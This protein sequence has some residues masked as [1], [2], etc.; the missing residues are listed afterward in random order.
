MAPDFEAPA[1]GDGN[2]VYL[3]R[4]GVSDGTTSDTLDL[5]VTVTDTGPDEFA[6]P[7]VGVGFSQPLFVAPVPDGSGR[8]FVVQKGGLIRIL[9][10]ARSEEPTSELRSLMRISY[11]AFCL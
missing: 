4:I 3:V 5:M 9:D 11:A 1:D 6:V 7:R 10:P 8:G 2:N